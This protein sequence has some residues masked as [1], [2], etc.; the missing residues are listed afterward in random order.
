MPHPSVL[1]MSFTVINYGNYRRIFPTRIGNIFINRLVPY[2]FSD[3]GVMEDLKRFEKSDSLEFKIIESTE[4]KP[5]RKEKIDFNL[6]RINEL[7]SI[8]AGKGIKGAFSMRK[9]DLIK[10]LEEKNATSF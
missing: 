7:R 5:E 10:K 2:D 9:A 3:D 6:Y 4:P 8:V 1:K